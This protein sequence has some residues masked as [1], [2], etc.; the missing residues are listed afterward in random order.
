MHFQ[1]SFWRFRAEGEE[2][3]GPQGYFIAPQEEA[4]LVTKFE[5]LRG[6]R[7]LKRLSFRHSPNAVDDDVIQFIFREMTALEELEVSHCS[8]LTDVGLAGTG[9]EQDKKRVSL[10]SLQGQ[11]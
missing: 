10:R 5:L 8:R 3:V 2:R 9:P 4:P 7:Y 1:G 6:F 11:P